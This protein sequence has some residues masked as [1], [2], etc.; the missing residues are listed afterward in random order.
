MG[1]YFKFYMY[2]YFYVVLYIEFW[3]EQ[4]LRWFMIMLCVKFV[5]YSVLV[6][7]ISHDFFFWRNIAHDLLNCFLEEDY[8]ILSNGKMK[9]SWEKFM[10]LY[11]I[12]FGYNFFWTSQNEIY[13]N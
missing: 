5:Y 2:R 7:N 1:E 4:W 12:I 3:W 8:Q 10:L 6:N 13:I 9:C 11:P